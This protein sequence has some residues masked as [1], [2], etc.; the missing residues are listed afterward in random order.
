MIKRK[1]DTKKSMNKI[2][3]TW[4]DTEF[5]EQYWTTE[6]AT[7]CKW[8]SYDKF[9][10]ENPCEFNIIVG[11]NGIS[12]SWSLAE[13]FFQGIMD[14]RKQIWGRIR[15]TEKVRCIQEWTGIFERHKI[16]VKNGT[17]NDKNE[18]TINADGVYHYTK[19]VMPFIYMTNIAVSQPSF[20]GL[21]QMVID[22]ILWNSEDGIKS[23]QPV[24]KEPIKT[25]LLL[26]DRARVSHQKETPRTF[27]VANLHQPE[28][29]FFTG[30]QYYPNW[31]KLHNG[32]SDLMVYITPQGL[33]VSV[34]VLGNNLIQQAAELNWKIKNQIER[35]KRLNVEKYAVPD[36][37]LQ[38]IYEIP[39]DF[40]PWYN[41]NWQ[42]C[43]FTIGWSNEYNS[44]YCMK[45]IG[46]HY[47]DLPWFSIEIQ[48]HTEL[49]LF[50][51]EKDEVLTQ[52][53]DILR[54]KH[55][56]DKVRYD[57]PYTQELIGCEFIGQLEIF[58]KIKALGK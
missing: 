24:F 28:S 51:A 38:K 44:V 20:E 1:K 27:L 22:E 34:L 41:L 35:E 49:D 54:N 11:D 10:A 50:I 7:G 46:Y 3:K 39:S 33:K 36:G 19:L 23:A 55:D 6:D 40:E 52:F 4:T 29:D 2:L 18:W 47:E 15:Q 14:G 9:I 25:L 57:S 21:E 5:I 13:A 48:N 56:G 42:D 26:Q 16:T 53:R 12:K 32:E 31:E 37:R 43:T 30:L 58:R 45:K 8:L 17:P